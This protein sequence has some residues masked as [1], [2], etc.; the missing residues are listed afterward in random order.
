MKILM[1]DTSVLEDIYQNPE[2][3]I[4]TSSHTGKGGGEPVAYH[5]AH[6]LSSNG[7]IFEEVNENNGL[8]S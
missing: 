4:F 6:L 8:N 5:R 1:S 7:D 2:Y 3:V